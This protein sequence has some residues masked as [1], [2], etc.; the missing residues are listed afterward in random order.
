MD[1]PNLGYTLIY[2]C[3][4]GFYLAG[5]SE[6]RICRSDGRWSGKPP[7]CKGAVHGNSMSCS[8]NQTLH[9]GRLSAGWQVIPI[10]SQSLHREKGFVFPTVSGWAFIRPASLNLWVVVLESDFRRPPVTKTAWSRTPRREHWIIK[11]YD[12]KCLLSEPCLHLSWV[13]LTMLINFCLEL[14]RPVASLCCCWQLKLKCG[15]QKVFHNVKLLQF[16]ASVGVKVHPKGR[17][18][19]DVQKNKIRGMSFKCS[20]LLRMTFKLKANY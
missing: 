9:Q 2:T 17:G 20:Q 13:S 16:C 12:L 5:G 3:Q 6:H 19:S 1:L 7:L 8:L 18:E 4:D 15:A 14:C 10:N 11:L